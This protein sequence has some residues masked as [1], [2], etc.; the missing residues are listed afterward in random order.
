MNMNGST[1]D[2][3]EAGMNNSRA[4]ESPARHLE[5]EDIAVATLKPE[6]QPMTG[7][8]FITDKMTI[9]EVAYLFDVSLEE[10]ADILAVINEDG[11]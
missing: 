4:P 10:A 3:F 7:T 5:F 2:C 8:P 9:K 1:A 6:E 11:Q